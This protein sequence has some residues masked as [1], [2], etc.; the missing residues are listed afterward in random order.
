MVWLSHRLDISDQNRYV[1][2]SFDGPYLGSIYIEWMEI[3]PTLKFSHFLIVCMYRGL[4][5]KLIWKTETQ[6]WTP[7]TME[8]KAQVSER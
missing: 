2:S 6:I 7:F 4:V 8:M 3:S 5:L 1:L